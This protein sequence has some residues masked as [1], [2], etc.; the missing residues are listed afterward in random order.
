MEIREADKKDYQ[1]I[2]AL[3]KQLHPTDPPVDESKRLELFTNVV[4]SKNNKIV[5]AECENEIVSSCYLNIIPNLTRGLHPY[6]LIENVI[7]NS[8]F[9]NQGFGKAVVRQAI[10]TA[11][12]NGCYKVMLLT[13]TKTPIKRL[14]LA[15]AWFHGGGYTPMMMAGRETAQLVLKDFIS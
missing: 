6:A 7:T 1:S 2:K 5:V 15:S 12:D 11:W 14:Y 10:Q 13:G 4:E 9:R 8:K 3:Y